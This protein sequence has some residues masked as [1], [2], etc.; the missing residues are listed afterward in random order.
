M[1]ETSETNIIKLRGLPWN[2]T[3][4]EIKEFLKDVEF[5]NGDDGIHLVTSP[6]DGRPNGEAF[7]E[8]ASEKDFNLAFE[9]NKNVMGHRYI[10]SMER[11]DALEFQEEMLKLKSHPTAIS[12]ESDTEVVKD[13][14]ETNGTNES[15]Q[16]MEVTESSPGSCPEISGLTISGEATDEDRESKTAEDGAVSAVGTEENPGSVSDKPDGKKEEEKKGTPEKAPEAKKKEDGSAKAQPE[17][18]KCSAKTAKRKEERKRAKLRQRQLAAKYGI[19]YNSPLFSLFAAR[20]DEFETIM[21]KQCVVQAET[22]VKLRGLPYSVS[23]NEIETFFE[24]LELKQDRGSIHIVMDNRGRATGEAFVQ[25]VNPDDTEKAL[26]KNREKIGHRYIEIFRSSA[27]EFRRSTFNSARP[28]PYDRNDRGGLRMGFGGSGG[29]GMMRNRGNFKGGDRNDGPGGWKNRPFDGFGGGNFNGGGGGGGG[30]NGGS[31]FGNFGGYEGGGGGGSGPNFGGNGGNFGNFGAGGGGGGYGGGN[32]GGSGGNFGGAGGN[33]GGNSNFG[34]FGNRGDDFM[35]RNGPGSGGGFGAGGGFNN[36]GGGGGGGG[37]GGGGGNFG[38]MGNRNGG[39]MGGG[40]GT[41]AGGDEGE[42]GGEEYC[43]HL[44]GMPYYCDEQDIYKFF[45]PLK[46]INC[47]VIYNSRG[48]HSGEAD[49]LFAT[50][51]EAMAAMSKH[52]EKMGFR[53]IELFYNASNNARKRE[54]RF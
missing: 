5:V 24:G 48:L 54:R 51:A 27:S 35:A 9:Y 16:S 30:P 11:V 8:C 49:A 10:E 36:G 13:T 41:W 46:P 42:E 26:K 52:K 47:Q 1:A 29:I 22:F 21:R 39:S 28:G 15:T 20:P 7:V 45:A 33:F 32:G 12:E 25:F 50:Q 31:G 53:Y 23:P 19:P 6:R 3:V 14:K 44:R 2:V 40:N 4:K 34:N 37:A 18:P 43:V 17:K 38:A